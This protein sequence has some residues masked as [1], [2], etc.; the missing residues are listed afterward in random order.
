MYNVNS[1]ASHLGMSQKR[2]TD[3][4]ES[5]AFLSSFG[6]VS[7][8]PAL[9]FILFFS[10]VWLLECEAPQIWSHLAHLRPVGRGDVLFRV[11]F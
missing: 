7:D 1:R 9:T 2:D 4:W 5:T 11:L 10:L 3:R 8:L 6:G